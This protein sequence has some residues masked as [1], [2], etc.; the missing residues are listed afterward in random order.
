MVH[1]NYTIAQHK[2]KVQNN[3]FLCNNKS[4]SIL[5]KF[6]EENLVGIIYAPKTETKVGVIHRIQIVVIYF[7]PIQ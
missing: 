5:C 7:L 4:S 1:N 2:G 3:K 6:L